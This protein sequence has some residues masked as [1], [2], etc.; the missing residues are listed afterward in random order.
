MSPS[1]TVLPRVHVTAW[2]LLTYIIPDFEKINTS[3][4][5]KLNLFSK[6]DFHNVQHIDV[7]GNFID[8]FI[9]I[10]I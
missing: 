1:K 9:K 4:I 7:P 5:N 8:M 6:L 10:N 3:V 2:A